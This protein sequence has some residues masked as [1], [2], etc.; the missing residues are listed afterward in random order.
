MRDALRRGR[1]MAEREAILAVVPPD[2]AAQIRAAELQ[3]SRLQREREDLTAGQGRYRDRPIAETIGELHHAEVNIAR[4]ERNL[5]G[6]RTSRSDRRSWRSQL[7]G[8]SVRP[9]SAG[10]MNIRRRRVA[11]IA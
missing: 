5:A 4:I 3:R 9:T 11:S 6:S 10:R 7:A 1:L 8:R 2:P